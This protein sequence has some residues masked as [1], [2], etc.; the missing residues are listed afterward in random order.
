[1]PVRKRTIGPSYLTGQRVQ[2][3]VTSNVSTLINEAVC[4]DVAGERSGG[5][6]FFV[7]KF[8]ASG[9]IMN[10]KSGN[11]EAFNCPVDLVSGST[12]KGHLGTGSLGLKTDSAYATTA[13]ARTNP[14]RPDV[15][16][17]VF[18]GE[19]GDLPS[20]VK[21]AG[22]SLI[23]MM[24][25]QHL[26]THF[27]TIPLVRDLISMCDFVRLTELR[28]KELNALKDKGLSRTRV[29]DNLSTSSIRKVTPQSVGTAF[30]G[31]ETRTTSVRVWVHLKWHPAPDF[32]R[33]DASLLSTARRA[34]LGLTVDASTAWELI[35]FSWLMDW[36]G[37]MGDYFAAK[38]NIVPSY[39][40]T[41][42][43]MRHTRTS[44]KITMLPSSNHRPGFS[45]SDYSAEFE[46]KSR[47]P[48]AISPFTA[49]VPFLS[50]RQLAV[51]GSLTVIRLGRY[52]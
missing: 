52:D 37:S 5:Y 38:R 14:S 36:F 22:G 50:G 32:P 3:G 35:P 25:R 4:E 47:L 16:I 24:A 41:P 6:P 8:S 51:L 34:A 48:T 1:M 29:L 23:K 40:S 13:Q 20:L 28:M 9:G 2:Y 27:G 39:P 49:Y 11:L 42:L 26:R 44:T 31:V 17:P 33:T 18:I 12:Y 10:G 46:S 15:D 30:S 7:S 19:L 21:D 43:V 45:V